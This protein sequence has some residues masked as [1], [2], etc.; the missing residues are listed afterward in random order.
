MHTV[1]LSRQPTTYLPTQGMSWTRTS[2]S[3]AQNFRLGIVVP[4]EN[5]TA[6]PEFGRLIGSEVNL[7]TSRFPVIQN[8]GLREM[9]ETYNEVL[10]DVLGGFGA[11]R[12][13]AAIVSCSASHYLL[14]P[15]GDLAF[16]EELS[17]RTG[18]PVRS[19]TQATLAACE[20][21]GV[22]RL[23]LVSPYEPWLTDVS[24]DFWEKA[25]LTVD[26]VVLVPAGDRFDPY[27]VTT[28]QLLDR[29]GRQDISEDTALLFTGTGMSTVAALEHLAAGSDR[30]LLSSNLASAWWVLREVGLPGTHPLLERLGGYVVAP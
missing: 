10:P 4:P 25:D 14:S 20:A 16:C 7:Y 29:L 15:D 30:V 12:L 8:K 22:H 27:Q 2:G 21:L 23:T 19:S 18:F 9:L 1:P 3:G 11:L 5:P 17:E 28:A 24:K 26:Q 6:E 13:D